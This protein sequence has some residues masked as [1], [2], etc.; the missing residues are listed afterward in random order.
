MQ[1]ADARQATQAWVQGQA[2]QEQ[3]A[4]ARVSTLHTMYVARHKRMTELIRSCQ[5]EVRALRAGTPPERLSALRRDIRDLEG[6]LQQLH[7]AWMDFMEGIED[8]EYLQRIRELG[9]ADMQHLSNAIT[10][11]RTQ[12]RGLEAS[13]TPVVQQ[14]GSRAPAG[15]GEAVTGGRSADPAGQQSGEAQQVTPG[16]AGPR[17]EAR[18]GT[19]AQSTPQQN[20]LPASPLV[21]SAPQVTRPKVKIDALKIPS[22]DGE[23][24]SYSKFKRNFQALVERQGYEVTVPKGRPAK[25]ARLSAGGGT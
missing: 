7:A 17:G 16:P 8:L 14:P 21:R 23:L 3:R 22:F 19:T 24:L 15:S 13:R 20:E 1:A 4:H 2:R 11:L 12:V 9:T 18:E 5:E 10:R 25:I 6:D